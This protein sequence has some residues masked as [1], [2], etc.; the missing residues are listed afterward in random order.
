MVA[1]YDRFVSLAR[2]KT[3]LLD[4]GAYHG[5]YS[6]TFCAINSSSEAVAI[7]PTNRSEIA[8]ANVNLNGFDI[9]IIQCAAFSSSGVVR[10]RTDG[11]AFGAAH[12]KADATFP[13]RTLDEI[14]GD[15]GFVPDMVKIDT[16]GFELEVL[17]GASEILSRRPAMI[18]E[19][20]PN[21]LTSIGCSQ[22]AIHDLLLG[23]GYRIEDVFGRPL[24]E[25]EFSAK[26]GVF[27]HAV[28]Q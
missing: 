15:R 23:L 20:H 28:C 10:G 9:E 12:G 14:C 1:E 4:V 3:R 5:I 21:F 22:R 8:R 2:G 11:F 16:E 6:L 19:V 25:D 13:C 26:S 7:E 24:E 18:V 27:F 17:R